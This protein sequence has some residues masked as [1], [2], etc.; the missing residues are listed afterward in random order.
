LDGD[1]KVKTKGIFC[2]KV[3]A[4]IL[5][6]EIKRK[7]IQKSTNGIVPMPAGFNWLPGRKTKNKNSLFHFHARKNT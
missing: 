1:E 7:T 5:T 6:G 2:F 4:Y 3:F